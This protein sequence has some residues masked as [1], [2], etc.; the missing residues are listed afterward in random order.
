[1]TSNPLEHVEFATNPEPRCPVI[2]LLDTSASMSG[3]PIAELNEGLHV[4]ED[5]LKTDTLASLR[6]EIAVITFGETVQALDVIGNGSPIGF[7][8]S[9]AFVTV[10][11]FVP[12]T[13][14]AS[15]LTPMGEAL[16]RGLALLQERKHIYNQNSLDYF[17]PWMFLITDGAPNDEWQSAVALVKQEEA[18][19]GV[20]LYTV[21]V[22]GADMGTLSQFSEQRQPL[23]LRGLAF[24]E[25]FQ[26]LSKSLS[27]VSRSRP[28]EQVPLPEVGWAVH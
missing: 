1:M 23:K 21:G 28:G 9:Q 15:G 3:Q 27:S 22:A 7:D 12:P 4:M 26:W 10:E 2:L 6:V 13:L 25:L 18:R 20:A 11:H 16:R 14:H 24:R 19:Q 17:R 8:A 5:A